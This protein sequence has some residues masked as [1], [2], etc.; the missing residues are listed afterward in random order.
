MQS[1]TKNKS[2]K[3]FKQ[4]EYLNKFARFKTACFPLQLIKY[5]ETQL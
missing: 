2:V 3:A 4:N 5:S 1:Q